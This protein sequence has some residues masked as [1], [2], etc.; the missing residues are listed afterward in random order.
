MVLIKRWSFL[1][2]E[3][4][5][6]E[7]CLIAIQSFIWVVFINRWSFS[8]VVYTE[9]KT[10]QKYPTYYHSSPFHFTESRRPSNAKILINYKVSGSIWISFC[11]PLNTPTIILN[12]T[13][14]H[15]SIMTVTVYTR[16]QLRPLL[17]FFFQHLLSL[18]QWHCTWRLLPR[19]DTV[20]LLRCWPSNEYILFRYLCLTVNICISASSSQFSRKFLPISNIFDR[21]AN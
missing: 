1:G 10:N 6:Y 12:Y 21:Y 3:L 4:M 13:R 8:E 19:N 18:H 14:T 7:S 17:L 5:Y 9:V 15:L 16:Q 11:G 2:G 20:G